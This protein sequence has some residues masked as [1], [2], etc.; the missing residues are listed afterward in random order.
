[1]ATARTREAMK[2][3]Q[4]RNPLETVGPITDLRRRLE[5]YDRT[6]ERWPTF[7]KASHGELVMVFDDHTS[8]FNECKA[9]MTRQWD[10]LS[11]RV[12]CCDMPSAARL[13]SWIRQAQ[14]GSR[15]KTFTWHRGEIVRLLDPI[16]HQGQ[17]VL[18][19]GT[20]VK[21]TKARSMVFADN[22]GQVEW[23]TPGGKPRTLQLA[24]EG[25]ELM[26]V[27]LQPLPG[28]DPIVCMAELPGKDHW[29]QAVIDLRKAARA[30]AHEPELHAYALERIEQLAHRVVRIRPCAAITPELINGRRFNSVA[31][32]PDLGQQVLAGIVSTHLAVAA[33]IEQLLVVQQRDDGW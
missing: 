1:M 21:I 9:R 33:A 24:I 17:Q 27:E 3:A 2:L 14:R 15:D 11:F 12:V 19:A 25:V 10:P 29:H 28:G 4:Y 7:D 22:L 23:A 32:H 16:H 6:I 20:E 26:A 31:L 8:W 5:H 13:N 30:M 18:A